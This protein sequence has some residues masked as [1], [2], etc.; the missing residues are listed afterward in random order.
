MKPHDQFCFT[1]R[2]I[3][4]VLDKE[5]HYSFLTPIMKALLEKCKTTF[6]LQVQIPALN[7][8]LSGPDFFK[9]FKEYCQSEEWKYFLEKKVQPLSDDYFRGYLANL[10][11]GKL[12]IYQQI[13]SNDYIVKIKT[14]RSQDWQDF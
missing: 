9:H 14:N 4:Q 7:L 1:T 2:I 13:W 10:P 12:Q 3:N 6:N 8:R 5:D 11:T